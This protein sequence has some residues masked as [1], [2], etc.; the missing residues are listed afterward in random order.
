MLR[1]LRI[2]GI[3]VFALLIGLSA[4]RIQQLYTSGK[5]FEQYNS[6]RK[7]NVT[8][9][10]FSVVGLGILG[11]FELTR[12]KRLET[13]RGFAPVEVSDEPIDDGLDT[14]NIYSAPESPDKWEGRRVRTSNARHSEPRKSEDFWLGLLRILSFSTPLVYT[15]LFVVCLSG[16]WVPLAVPLTV[17]YSI[18]GFML[19]FSLISAIGIMRQKTWGIKTGYAIAIIHLLFFPVGTAAGLL[20]LI[21]LVGATPAIVLSPREQRSVERKKRQKNLSVA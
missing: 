21:G 14:A 10:A 6:E 19:I 5:L 8:L 1:A 11:F 13:R 15:F 3:L 4:H 12:A 16:W 17:L 2:I 18:F 20:L 7:A 9:L